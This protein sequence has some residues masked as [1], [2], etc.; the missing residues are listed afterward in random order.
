M[1]VETSDLG[2]CVREER[3]V[4]PFERVILDGIGHVDVTQGNVER[5][6]VE[7]PEDLQS[8][9]ETRVEE[10]TL[11]L[12]LQERVFPIHLQD[13]SIRYEITMPKICG[14]AIDGTGSIDAPHVKSESLDASIDGAGHIDIGVV[15]VQHRG[16]EIDGSGRLSIASAA[17]HDA[18][19]EIDGAGTIEVD[20]LVCHE[21]Q[22]SIDGQGRVVAKG[23]T[24]SLSIEIDGAGTVDATRCRRA[25]P[26]F[27]STVSA[28]SRRGRRSPSKLAS[29]ALEGLSSLETRAS[30]NESMARAASRRPR[31][32]Q[33]TRSCCPS[34]SRRSLRGFC[35]PSQSCTL[36]SFPSAAQRSPHNRSGAK[37][38]WHLRHRSGEAEA[39]VLTSLTCSVAPL[40]RQEGAKEPELE[41][42][43]PP[44]NRGGDGEPSAQ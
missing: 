15:D 37:A 23:T 42:V 32:L 1:V 36:S 22:V 2:T 14:L 40:T 38:G 4:E 11:T 25:S 29:M 9:I 35:A 41:V 26:T 21:T 18:R 28:R 31:T 19:F 8:K 10:R 17:A 43:Q 30:V 34:A 6:V 33:G 20:R 5:L 24:D 16:L 13:R 44:L 27:R 12:R 3:S 39:D 7:A